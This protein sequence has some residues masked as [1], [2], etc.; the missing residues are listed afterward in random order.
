MYLYRAENNNFKKKTISFSTN[1][2]N[3][4]MRRC[5][6]KTS[7]RTTQR[8]YISFCHLEIALTSFINVKHAQE[9]GC[10]TATVISLFDCTFS[11][12]RTLNCGFTIANRR[13]IRKLFYGRVG[14]GKK[15]ISFS[16][17][18]ISNFLLATFVKIQEKVSNKIRLNFQ[19][20]HG[21]FQIDYF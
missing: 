10:P 21:P 13:Y 8:R 7:Q 17:L 11:Y 3:L 1:P 16:P 18:F 12:S 19:K 9:E 4:L 5:F 6:W 15:V 2:L 20:Q 14:C